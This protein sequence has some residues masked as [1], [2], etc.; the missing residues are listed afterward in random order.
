MKALR[1]VWAEVDLGA[2][3]HNVSRLAA[4]A[5]PGLLCAVVKANGY[6]HGAVPVARAALEGGAT[7]LG[8]ALVEEGVELRDAGI[9]G[10]ILVLSEPP[11]DA[12]DEVVGRRL[13]PTL[14]TEA[15]AEAAAKAVAA[16]GVDARLN[17]HL[18]VDTGMHRV[19]AAPEAALGLADVVNRRPELRLAALWTHLAVA[20]QPDDEFT[21]QQL[22]RFERVRLTLQRRGILPDLV[23]AANSAGLIAHPASRYNF[24]RCGIAIYGIDPSP[25]LAGRPERVDLR[26]ALSLK[27]Q[28]SFVKEVPAGDRISYGLRYHFDTHAV[29]ATVPAGYADGVTRRLSF[30]GGQVLIGGHRYPIA[31]TITMDQLMVDCGP[32]ADIAP[33]DEVVLIG[34]QGQAEGQ[35]IT[36]QEWADRL[37]TIA[38][39]VVCGVGPRVP[40]VYIG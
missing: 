33:G 6:G 8:V 5:R 21:A 34:G 2:I 7:W 9:E 38:Y 4:L 25:A 35:E 19:G 20:D 36:A 39:E 13:T 14:Y 23:H 28:V 31:G 26:P 11:H 10:P 12:M 15:G 17:V 27:A 18:K 40:R 32:D 24:A 1:P 30:T 29:V 22:E 16:A 37:D 3:R